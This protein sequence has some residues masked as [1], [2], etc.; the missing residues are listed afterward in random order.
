MRVIAQK[1]IVLALLFVCQILSAQFPLSS[2]LCEPAM[3]RLQRVAEDDGK[4]LSLTGA[5][6]AVL[7]ATKRSDQLSKA[8]SGEQNFASA[9]HYSFRQYI[10]YNSPPQSRLFESPVCVRRGFWLIYRALLL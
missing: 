4:Q 7:I 8:E 5:S 2:S 9:K 1:S 3:S 10:D 6:N